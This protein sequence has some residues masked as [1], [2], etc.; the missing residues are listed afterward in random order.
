M[1][2]SYQE[3][4]GKLIEA[5]GGLAHCDHP[6]CTTC[7]G[8][9]GLEMDFTK[10]L[11]L[12]IYSDE[13]F[14]QMMELNADDLHRI[15]F[16][17][18]RDNGRA[19]GSILKCMSHERFQRLYERYFSLAI[20]DAELANKLL[21]WTLFG[22]RLT[23]DK[24]EILIQCA[25]PVLARDYSARTKLKDT[26]RYENRGKN[27]MYSPDLCK[28]YDDDMDK[29]LNELKEKTRK[30][31]EENR[32]R[33]EYKKYL[34]CLS[35]L[36]LVQRLERIVI[37]EI[38]SQYWDSAWC[39]ISEAELNK[40]TLLEIQGL[41]EKCFSIGKYFWRDVIIALS[42]KRNE[43]RIMEMNSLRKKYVGTNPE[44]ILNI[45]LA[46]DQIP[47]EH[48]PHELSGSVSK[49]WYES[50]QEKEQKKFIEMLRNTRLRKWH[51]LLERVYNSEKEN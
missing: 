5:L 29:W 28:A 10:A 36:P 51:R 30:W 12:S 1:N 15:K 44:E 24:L 27:I 23:E 41:I 13:L 42:D 35:E 45:L 50:L 8:P 20:S 2:N 3:S 18:V 19:I 40:L 32:K 26:L 11:S 16:D 33:I 14:N 7:G 6:G 4:K 47:I 17:V 9:I 43:I 49:E 46:D 38:D 34:A 25:S 37:E 39:Y 48:Y 22:K 21:V 31:E